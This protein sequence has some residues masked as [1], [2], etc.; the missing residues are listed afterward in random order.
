[1]TL[2]RGDFSSSLSAQG[3]LILGLERPNE[4][5]EVSIEGME[6]DG[7]FHDP[8]LAV[9]HGGP[10]V[11]YLDGARQTVQ[12]D[13]DHRDE[14][15]AQQGQVGEVVG[16]YRLARQVCVYVPEATESLVASTKPTKVGYLQAFGVTHEQIADLA[17]AFNQDAHLSIH[18]SGDLGE[19]PR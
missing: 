11:A 9:A 10:K 3:L 16:G 13:T 5:G 1:L 4:H 14:V 7:V 17:A 6:G 2:A 18:F 12:G 8:G 19:S 15:E